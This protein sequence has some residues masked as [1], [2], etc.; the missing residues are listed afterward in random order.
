MKNKKWV[1]LA[2][3][4]ALFGSIVGCS[5]GG[6]DS[7]KIEDAKAAAED[8]SPITIQYWH[9]HSDEQMAGVNYMI[10]E[11][12]KKYPNITVEP[13][14][15]GAYTDLHKKLQAAVAAKDVPAV[16]NV[17]VSALPNFADGGVFADLTPY[18]K[19]DNVDL[20]DFSKGMLQA[21]SY[22]DKQYGFPLIVSTSVMVYNKTMLDQLGVK[23]PQTWSEIEDFNKKVTVKESGKTT[24]YAFSVPGW[25]TWYYDPWITNGGGTILTKDEKSGFDQ[26]DSMRWIQNFQ[27]WIKDGSMQM[28]YG[29]G[30]SDVMRQMF[31]EG[32]VAMVQHSSAII[33]TYVQNA[34]FEVG[35][36]FI[37]GDKERKSHI[38]GA[39]IVIMDGAPAKQ[40]E[41]A[42]KFV[43]FMVGA[44][45]N[46]KWADYTGYLPTHK[47]VVNTEEGKKYFEKWPQY[48]AVF[49]NFDNVAPRVQHPAYPEFS[50][51]YKEIVG[52]MVLNNEDPVPLLKD[53]VKEIN[54]IIADYK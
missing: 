11:F 14:F 15:Q 6:A 3:S 45:N 27:K 41:A 37:P 42:W 22:N 29:K 7:G 50:N 4:A 19:R 9:S 8:N 54:E 13:V 12:N 23:P 18:I 53:S 46:I 34:K 1:S 17:E 28:G 36:S 49:E 44:E 24:R 31:L 2:V 10:Q 43:K 16:T 39:G 25:D 47:S 30:A 52:K 21:Y 32:K 48:K 51:V 5:N 20:N 35:V 33:K 38:G 26:P 40:K